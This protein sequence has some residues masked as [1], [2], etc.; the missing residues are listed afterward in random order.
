MIYQFCE[1]AFLHLVVPLASEGRTVMSHPKD[2]LPIKPLTVGGARP[3]LSGCAPFGPLGW[4][5]RI[6]R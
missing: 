4:T 6:A 3:S 1:H 2:M 5:S